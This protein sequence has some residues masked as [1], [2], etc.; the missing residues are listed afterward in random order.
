MQ[1]GCPRSHFFS[2]QPSPQECSCSAPL[3]PLRVSTGNDD[4]LMLQKHLELVPEV[5]D[6]F[7]TSASHHCLLTPVMET[8]GLNKSILGG[9]AARRRSGY[10]DSRTACLTM[11]SRRERHSRRISRNRN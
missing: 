7:A 6:A 10:E 9:T 11:A 3:S 8:M 5:R 2:W 1:S 4:L